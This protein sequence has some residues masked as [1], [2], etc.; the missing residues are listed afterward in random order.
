VQGVLKNVMNGN[1]INVEWGGFHYAFS[2]ENA[3][4][5]EDIKNALHQNAEFNRIFSDMS[6]IY[7]QYLPENMKA[8][9]F[10]DHSTKVGDCYEL[11]SPEKKDE[12][13][14]KPN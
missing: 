13:Q 12:T 5:E 6:K 1:K 7:G 11:T 4:V 9:G 8:L 14:K 10:T 3:K 2:P